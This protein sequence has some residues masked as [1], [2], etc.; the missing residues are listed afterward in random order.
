[1]DIRKYQFFHVL[2][3]LPFVETL[4]LYGSRARG[5]NNERSDIDLAISCPKANDSDWLQVEH[6][7]EKADTL[8]KIDSVRFDQLG[9]NSALKQAIIQQGRCLFMKK[10]ETQY[11]HKIHESFEKLNKALSQLAVALNKPMESDRTNIDASIQRFE[12][13]IELFWKL[14]KRLIESLGGEVNFP[15]EVLQEA[16]KAN[17]IDDEKVWLLMLAD[18][19]QT[20]HTYDEELA[21]KIYRNLHKYHPIMQLTYNNL[22]M[23]FKP[24]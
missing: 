9:E 11:Q 5:D 21:D 18:R 15:K 17:M 13:T 10:E 8:L 20:S 22:R 16:Y 24:D 2:T 1:M 7:L 14:L 6:I 4:W 19:N 3:K 12:F 23:K